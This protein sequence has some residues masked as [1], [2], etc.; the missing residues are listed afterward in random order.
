MGDRA[1]GRV[2]DGESL[3]VVEDNTD[4]IGFLTPPVG[5]PLLCMHLYICNTAEL[6][7]VDNRNNDISPH[8]EG[9]IYPIEGTGSDPAPPSGQRDQERFR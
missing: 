5:Q 4:R 8:L 2:I 9:V 7:C 1:T 6:P 3:T